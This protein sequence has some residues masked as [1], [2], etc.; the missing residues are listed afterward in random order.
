MDKAAKIARAKRFLEGS[1]GKG[2]MK[3]YLQSTYFMNEL[4]EKDENELWSWIKGAG[5]K[6][7]FMQEVDDAIDTNEN[8]YTNAYVNNGYNANNNNNNNN[9]TRGDKRRRHKTIRKTHKR[10]MHN[11]RS[12]RKRN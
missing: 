11:R 1:V 9:N 3:K 6:E 5:G 12:M 4:M 7:Q 10:K 8:D 2:G